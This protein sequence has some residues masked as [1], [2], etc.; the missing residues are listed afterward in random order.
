[1]EQQDLQAPRP[2]M[3]RINKKRLYMMVG[4][5]LAGYA[6]MFILPGQGRLELA[7]FG[8]ISTIVAI[9][10]VREAFRSDV[11]VVIDH[12]G[13][14]DRR[15]GMGTIRWQDIEGIYVKKLKSIDHVCLEVADEQKYF[16]R[17]SAFTNLA[18]RFLRATNKISPFNINTGVLDAATDEIYAAIVHGREYY[19]DR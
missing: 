8:L 19:G 9:Y 14:F 12:R 3:A 15:L 5:A 13:V 18:A 11:K 2:L 1:M 10:T 4:V 16:A 6:A 17:R 7:V